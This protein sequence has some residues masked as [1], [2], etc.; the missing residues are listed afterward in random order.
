MSNANDAI[1]ALEAKVGI[2]GSADPSSLDYKV[3]QLNPLTTKGDIIVRS[4]TANARLPVGTDGYMLV[5][6][7][8]QPLGVKYTTPSA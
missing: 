6:D 2:N 8:T 1:E 7:S 3:T 4:A 5:A